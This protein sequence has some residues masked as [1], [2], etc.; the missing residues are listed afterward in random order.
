MLALSPSWRYLILACLVLSACGGGDSSPA[1]SATA[2]AGSSSQSQG[3]EGTGFSK[4]EGV[5]T[6]V[7]ANSLTVSGIVLDATHAVV[8]VNGVRATLADVHVGAEATVT[9]EVN[10]ANHTGV[11]STID[12]EWSG[13][14]VG[15][16]TI[17][18]AT[19]FGDAVVT[20]DGAIRLYVGGPYSD[21][22][23]LQMVRPESS[24]QF[25]GTIQAGDGQWAG[26]GVIIGQQC[27]TNPANRFCAQPAPATFTAV[28]GLDSATGAAGLQGEIQLVT[29]G[30]PETWSL[31]LGLW[32]DDGPLVSGQF[33]EVIAEFASSSD[34]VVSLDGSGKL[35]FQSSGSGCVGNGTLAPH[36][37]G[38]ANIYDVTLLMESCSGAYAYLNGTYGGLALATPSS[39]WD[40]DSLVRIWLSKESGAGSPAAITMLDE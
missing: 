28:V 4:I 1:S 13:H 22:G 7:G 40:Y 21:S 26:S 17:A 2:A 10:D 29:S 11:A 36:S 24:E 5:V 27:A 25:V 31:N 6:A 39:A 33:K 14:Y 38:P 35:F 32:I 20:R 23:A 18:G 3:I 19:Y 37:A 30:G 8:F 34:V 9:G 15:A 16:V 12:V